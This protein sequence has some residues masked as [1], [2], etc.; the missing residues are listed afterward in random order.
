MKLTPQEEL[1][2]KTYNESVVEWEKEHSVTSCWEEEF[3][4]FT[5]LLPRG[6]VLEIGC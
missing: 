5:K 3:K 1:T 2:I 4:T 6:K